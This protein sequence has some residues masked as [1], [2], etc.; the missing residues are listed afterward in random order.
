[1][2]SIAVG[3][4]VG[5]TS[6]A[7]VAATATAARAAN[8][9]DDATTV[10]TLTDAPLKELTWIPGVYSALFL[11]ELG[12]AVTPLLFAGYPTV[13][14]PYPHKR[15]GGIT[16][17]WV[18]WYGPKPFFPAI[19]PLVQFMGVGANMLVAYFGAPLIPQMS[20]PYLREFVIASMYANAVYFPWY[21]LNDII[22]NAGDN[23]DFTKF[24]QQTGISRGWLLVPSL[25]AGY[26]LVRH[27]YL[28]QH[29]Q[30]HAGLIVSTAAKSA[31][32]LL[33]SAGPYTVGLSLS[34]IDAGAGLTLSRGL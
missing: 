29:S 6:A 12:H 25:V 13:F 28:Q 9:I 8:Q 22:F 32:G 2:V 1:M 19:N 20:N 4:C 26:F 24:K 21:I 15:S 33:F 31:P 17:G 3:G 14:K 34:P 18:E 10:Y 7:T 30:P 5:L 23:S 27:V 11:H 16:L